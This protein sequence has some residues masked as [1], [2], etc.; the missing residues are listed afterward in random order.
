LTVNGSNTGGQH[1]VVTSTFDRMTEHALSHW[2]A[3]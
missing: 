3:A 2:A 1:P